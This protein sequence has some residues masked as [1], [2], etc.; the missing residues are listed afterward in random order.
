MVFFLY[1]LLV[2]FV[3]I[4][5]GYNNYYHFFRDLP[6][7]PTTKAI[8]ASDKRFETLLNEA[9]KNEETLRRFQAFELALMATDSAPELFEKLARGYHQSFSWDQV[10]LLLNDTDYEI[11]RVLDTSEFEYVKYPELKFIDNT[12][13]LISIFSGSHKPIL[14]SFSDIYKSLFLE[15]HK[16]PASICL[17]PLVRHQKI[18]GSFNIGSYDKNRFYTENATDFLEHLA[19]VLA[20][21]IET[22]ISV[23][24]LKHLGIFD[25]LTGVNNRHFFNQ[26]LL[27]EAA[28]V[29]RS[30]SP[31]SCLFIDIDHFKN[32]NDNFGHQAGDEVL[33]FIA[34][35]IRNQV[36]TIDIVAR[37]GGEEFIVIL[38]QTDPDSAMEI[39]ERIRT[40]IAIDS[41]RSSNDCVINI[42]ASIGINTLVPEHCTEDLEQTTRQFIE[43]A[44]KA[45]YT[46]KNNGRN[47]TVIYR[48]N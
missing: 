43:Q 21:C 14:G 4:I 2:G 17:L 32:I 18:I 30:E 27:E 6:I 34:R 37:Y 47:Q 16:L 26:R 12:T 40:G 24:Q 41:F 48:D 42:T 5:E 9:R 3:I 29:K 11:R 45:L 15:K 38:L 10:S 1:K 8:S 46:A 25:N 7:V 31:M 20:V 36:R 13:E 35:V 33:Q 22:S 28:R 44:D 39:A 23:E 19:A